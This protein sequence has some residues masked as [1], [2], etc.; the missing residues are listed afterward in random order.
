MSGR[1]AAAAA[2]PPKAAPRV[3]TRQPVRLPV[4]AEGDALERD[5]DRAAN[6][7]VARRPLSL[8]GG[9][10]GARPPNIAGLAPQSAVEA[11][12]QPGEPLEPAVRG[13]LEERFERDF[14]GVRI[15]CDTLAD[16]ATRD[17][18]TDAY[19]VGSDVVVRPDRY[20]RDTPAGRHI[21]AH[22]LAHVVQHQACGTAAPVVM[23]Y[24][25]TFGGFLANLFQFWDYSKHQL[26]EYLGVL[27]RTNNIED[28]DDSDDKARQVVAEWKRDKSRYLL[29]PPLKVLLVREM[30]SGS[31]LGSDQ[32][33][34]I[35]LLEHTRSADLVEM[36]TAGPKPLTYA[37]IVARFGTRKARLELFE[38]RVLRQLGS[39]K[40]PAAGGK[41]ARERLDDVEKQHGIAF[42]ELAVSFQLAAGDLYKSFKADLV[43]P[44][45]GVWVNVS[46]TRERLKV[47]LSPSVLIDVVWPLSNADL[48][49]FT[50]TF[51]GLKPKLDI[52]GGLQLIT[53]SAHEALNEY[54][55]G[56]LA[57]TRFAEP[58]YD[59]SRDTQL[60]GEVLDN[61]IIGDI[62]R[63]K[64]N[65][66]KNQKPGAG[67]SKLPQQISSPTI[68]LNL[69]HTKGIPPGKGWT[70]VIEPGTKFQLRISMQATGAELLQNTA[71]LTKLSITSDG[72]F[73]FKDS[74]KIAGLTG[75]EMTPDFRITLVDVKAYTDLKE[76]LKREFPQSDLAKTIAK[77]LKKLDELRDA[78][79]AI[80]SLGGLLRPMEPPADS[81][82]DV[83][84]YLSEKVFG[85]AVQFVLSTSWDQI[86][87]A[88][89]VT[90]EQLRHFFGVD[91]P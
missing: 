3:R 58:G 33:A 46:L 26:D 65:F 69:V 86:K 91:R 13:D 42:S 61:A 40:T 24:G 5:A 19:A 84:K 60:I 44:E 11:I 35:D 22:E 80:T 76:V 66:E 51:A 52:Q 56:L 57:G 88:L 31:V 63:V 49:G 28:D 54:L 15:H 45:G 64:Y 68:T 74:Q 89:G 78:V 55:S 39:L 75:I 37:E 32:D 48:S 18:A 30:L 34:I 81:A 6:A 41:S 36:F 43:V 83:A 21:L 7:A 1:N 25:R 27:S 17:L 14:S 85:F 70:G 72:I 71:R 47:T 82:L 62:N 38:K 2:A 23:R 10:G 20:A 4:G 90:D 59:P 50:L 16:R 53:T 77:G 87:R 67:D 79:D 29:T 12:E 8:V 9:L 73:I